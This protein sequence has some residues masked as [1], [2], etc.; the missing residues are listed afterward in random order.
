MT[1]PPGAKI[2]SAQAGQ[3]DS[4]GLPSPPWCSVWH[5]REPRTTKPHPDWIAACCAALQLSMSSDCSEGTDNLRWPGL[6][7]GG[8]LVDHAARITEHA[9]FA[10]VASPS[11]RSRIGRAGRS[12]SGSSSS[13]SSRQT[14][15]SSRPARRRCQRFLTFSE[16]IPKRG[17]VSLALNPRGPGRAPNADRLDPW[18]QSS[19]RACRCG[20]PAPQTR[21]ST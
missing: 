5:R 2:D 3:V 13:K 18:R 8:R 12:G 20:R 1:S 14:F 16:L 11:Q 10:K 21:R 19:P 7:R 6:L 17:A 9:D 15:C 4:S